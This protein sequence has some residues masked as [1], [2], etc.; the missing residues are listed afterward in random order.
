MM[1]M[2]D[3]NDFFKKYKG[4]RI[5]ARF[6]AVPRKSSKALRG[7]YYNCVVP[8]F[9]MAIWGAGERLT[10][11]ETEQTLREWSPITRSEHIDITTGTYSYK[12][13]TI[14]D[15]SNS[16]LIEHIEFLKQKAAEEYNF[17]INDPYTL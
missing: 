13:R 16:E 5:I 1:Y 12:L 7:Y 10:E 6:I 14:P 8:E 17:Y 3:L 15:L 4:D 2:G 11:E 9:R